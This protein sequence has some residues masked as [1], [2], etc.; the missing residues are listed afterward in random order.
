MQKKSQL[1]VEV[2]IHPA[3]Q[4]TTAHPTHT[5]TLTHTYGHFIKA[6]L[7][8]CIFFDN[9]KKPGLNLQNRKKMQNLTQTVA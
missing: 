5:V 7:P 3:L 1:L 2:G 9:G 8:T 6:S 4:F